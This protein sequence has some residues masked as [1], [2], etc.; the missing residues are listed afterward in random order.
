MTRTLV[1]MIL[2]KFFI[3]AAMV[4]VL[5]SLGVSSNQVCPGQCDDFSDCNAYCVAHN[6]KTGKCVV[7]PEVG[8]EYNELVNTP[9][10]VPATRQ[11]RPM[12]SVCQSHTT[13]TNNSNISSTTNLTDAHRK[14][15][16]TAPLY[17][18]VLRGPHL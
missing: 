12:I 15:H 13:N 17:T 1:S 8:V 3:F 16:M 9:A 10:H 5:F 11:K 4:I 2:L 18:V 14:S 7:A 6:H